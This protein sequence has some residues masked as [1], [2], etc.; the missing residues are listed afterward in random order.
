MQP[1]DEY[2]AVRTLRKHP[3]L[4]GADVFTL[5]WKSTPVMVTWDKVN[6]QAH[7]VN[8]DYGEFDDDEL[9]EL[10]EFLSRIITIETN[11]EVLT[12]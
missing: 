8:W 4:T 9:D 11:A 7:S 6:A 3:S 12:V 5:V 10:N 2:T 1:I